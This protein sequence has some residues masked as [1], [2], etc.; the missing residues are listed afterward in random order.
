M[1]ESQSKQALQLYFLPLLC[2][3]NPVP[4]STSTAGFRSPVG[5]VS[6][7]HKTTEKLHSF[8]PGGQAFLKENISCCK[9]CPKNLFKRC[10]KYFFELSKCSYRETG[11]VMAS[12]KLDGKLWQIQDQHSR[13]CRD[14]I[15]SKIKYHSVMLNAV[16]C[17]LSSVL[18]FI[19]I[20]LTLLDLVSYNLLIHFNF[21]CLFVCFVLL[22]FS[23][24]VNLARSANYL[25][26]FSTFV[27]HALSLLFL[28]KAD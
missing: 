25:S 1:T 3:G 9:K 12:F 15:S 2:L 7:S 23:F 13:N 24:Q 16:I 28:T 19:C 18:S 17:P 6:L 11:N 27:F 20:W 10:I 5:P 21:S 8:F 14:Y 4:I 26:H 22:C